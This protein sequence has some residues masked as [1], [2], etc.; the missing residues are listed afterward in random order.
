MWQPAQRYPDPAIEILDPRF[1]KYRLTSAAVER[2][3]TG[4][5]WAEGPVWFGDGRCLLWSDIPNNRV[6]RWDE[7]TGAVSHFRKPSNFANGHTRDRQGRLLSCEHGTRRVTRTEYD[8]SI[9]VILD[10]FEGKRLNSPNDIVVKSDDSIWFT[11]PPFG[12]LGHYEGHAA[13]PE[14]PT[15]VYRVD[16]KTGKA[17]VVCS[18]IERPNGLCF[19]PDERLL[20]VVESGSTPRRIRV[21]DLSEDGQ[22][23]KNGR[24]FVQADPQGSPDGFRCDVDGNLWAGWGTGEGRDGVMVFAPDATPIGR[25]ALPERCA[26]VCFGGPARNRLFMAAS[27]SL[28]ALYV[29]TQGVRGG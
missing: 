10:C 21:F 28:Y 6:L 1:A 12:I 16:G 4:F 5:R 27:Q 23:L 3:A 29:N 9:T 17:T 25:I 22:G 18:D 26:N 13:E 19:S 14:L 20:Y 2:L 7:E 15:N 11:D 8:G 24:V